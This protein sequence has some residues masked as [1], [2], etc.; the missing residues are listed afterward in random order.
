MWDIEEMLFNRFLC[1]LSEHSDGVHRR[2]GVL[3]G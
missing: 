1:D 3:G 2:P